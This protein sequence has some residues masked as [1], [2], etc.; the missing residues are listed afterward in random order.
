[1]KLHIK[2]IGIA[3]LAAASLAGCASTKEAGQPLYVYVAENGIVTFRGETMHAKEVPANLIKAGARPE[4][5]IFI[6]AQGD[7]PRNHLNALVMSCGE[8]GLPNCTI[9]DRM[10]VSIVKG[11][12]AQ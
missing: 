5:H 8:A 7:I 1:M 3:V 12:A 4:T 11:K 2:L 6:V 9:R 10:T